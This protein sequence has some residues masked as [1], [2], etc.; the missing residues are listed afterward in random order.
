[1]NS[2]AIALMSTAM[3]L[4]AC[5]SD[6]RPELRQSKAEVVEANGVGL[7]G[8]GLNGVGLNGVGLNGVGLNGVG[9]NGV[10]LNGVG[11]NGVGLNGVGL[12]GTSFGGT[13]QG[14]PISGYDFIGAEFTGTLSD[15]NSIT[16]RVDDIAESASHA[17]VYLYTMSYATQ[18]ESGTEWQP[19]CGGDGTA[20]PVAGTWN[21]GVGV[22]GGG[23]KTA[24]S[25]A[26]T[27]ACSNQAIGKCVLLGYKPWV[28]SSLDDHHQ[29][30]TR[31]V[32]ADYCGNGK[33]WT[34]DG[35][36]INLYD[37]VGVQSDTESWTLEAEWDTNGARCISSYRINWSTVD[38]CVSDKVVSSGCGS[39][40]S[41]TLLI[42]EYETQGTP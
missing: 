39:F 18:G 21:Y 38:Q 37:N 7:N 27:F 40:S 25:T 9:L 5:A 22:T 31:M 11:L 1:M 33:S 32:R 8:V 26:F 10:G 42:N 17:D 6:Q 34:Q 28:S 36:A 14:T 29:T 15:S 19:L 13:Y 41:G 2:K 12:N 16:L 24:S 23:S 35:R 20:I 30:C 3:I 4:G